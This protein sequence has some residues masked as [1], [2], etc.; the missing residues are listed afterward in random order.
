MTAALDCSKLW[1]AHTPQ[2]FKYDMILKGVESAQKRKA[3]LNDDSEALSLIRKDVHLI[4]SEKPV[5]KINGPLDI[6]LAEFYLR[7]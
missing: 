2:S 1:A 5:V 6:N 7:Q 4:H 3:A